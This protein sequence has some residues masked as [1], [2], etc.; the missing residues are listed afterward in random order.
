MQYSNKK[1]ATIPF[2]EC[3]L[4]IA[5]HEWIR[6][7]RERWT[8][9]ETRDIQWTESFFKL[10]ISST[11]SQPRLY[12][13]GLFGS[14]RAHSQSSIQRFTHERLR[15]RFCKNLNKSTSTRMGEWEWETCV[16]YWRQIWHPIFHLGAVS[17]VGVGVETTDDCMHCPLAKTLYAASQLMNEWNS[18]GCTSLRF[19]VRI[20]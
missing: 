8:R 10:M 3:T 1:N 5:I 9:D 16:W 20:D 2:R 14:P 17:G 13:N 11:S 18:G 12:A 19:G 15:I 7:W 4:Q 6:K